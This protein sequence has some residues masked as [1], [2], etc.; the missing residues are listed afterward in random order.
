MRLLFLSSRLPFPPNRGDRLRTYYLLRNLGS[1]HEITLV[2]YVSSREEAELT[3]ELRDFC[4]EIHLIL[5]PTLR[6]VLATAGNLWRSLPLQLLYYRSRKMQLL[7]DRMLAK[8]SYDAA[9]VHL[10]RMASYVANTPN[11]YRIVDLTDMI[12]IEIEASLAYRPAASRMIYRI[13]RPR[14]AKYERHV[15]GWA[16]E[17]WMISDRDRLLLAESLPEANL[18]TVPN[19]VD[20][21]R[22]SPTRQQNRGM[23][24]LFVGN[25]DVFHNIDAVSFLINEILPRV[26]QRIPECTLDIIGAGKRPDIFELERNHG[27]MVRGFVPDLNQALNEAAVF[28][29]P[30]RFS[31]GVQNKVLEAMAAGVPVV[32]TS[33]VNEG[34]GARHGQD[35]LV[36]DGADELAAKIVILLE[37][38]QMRRR[39]AQAGRRFVE[40]RF[41]WQMAVERMAQI[42]QILLQGR[43]DVI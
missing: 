33:N 12:S 38:D 21:A 4:E 20:L 2:T 24:L 1:K 36:G 25:L 41:S 31:A 6:S 35:L 19:G 9:Y 28:I 8:G 17:T 29:A 18:R 5:R 34:L 16:E 10:F 30:L 39:L 32:T 11:L 43:H 13:E 22:F 42:E 3:G 7:V 37:D 40:Q 27:V 15:A 14:V 23:R 26:R